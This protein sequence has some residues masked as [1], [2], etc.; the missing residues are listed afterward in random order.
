MSQA[1]PADQVRMIRC[2]V[3]GEAYALDANRVQGIQRADRLHPLAGE[4]GLVGRLSGAGGEVSV[5]SL[6]RLLR[7][8]GR[9]A[10]GTEHVVLVNTGPQPWGLLVDRVS[11]MGKVPANAVELL[12]PLVRN[13]AT[14]YF[15]EVVKLE[16]EM[17]LCLSPERLRPAA[18]PPQPAFE[19]RTKPGTS[20]RQAAPANGP[21]RTRHRSGRQVVLFSTSEP[22]PEERPVTFGLSITQ[23]AEILDLPAVVA[24]PGAPTFTVGLV[25]WRSRAVPVIDL[26]R[27]LG[28]PPS[29]P[30]KGARLLISHTSRRPELVG[31]LV[32]PSIRV[33]RLPLECRSSDQA[34]S[35]DRTMVRGVL[36]WKTET[37]VIPD[38]NRLTE[39]EPMS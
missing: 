29:S 30:G 19:P 27:R 13:P 35:V 5:Y 38:M 12:P 21:M 17:L 14:D 7:R 32:R 36:K 15:Q 22:R 8:P 3:A 16:R 20:G 2:N 4:D 25:N 9:R 33:V 23:V 11:Q 37:L 39:C 10:D 24:V 28:L 34:L 31:F 1:K 26:T 18:R 6:A